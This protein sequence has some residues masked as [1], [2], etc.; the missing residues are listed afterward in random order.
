MTRLGR[1][2]VLEDIDTTVSS[3]LCEG[4][5]LTRIRVQAQLVS[6]PS[7]NFVDWQ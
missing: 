1:D 4:A 6:G 2:G 5:G 7:R 3:H